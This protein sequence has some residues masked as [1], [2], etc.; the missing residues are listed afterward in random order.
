MK[1]IGFIRIFTLW[2]LLVGL[3]VSCG[4]D[5]RPS[6]VLPQD[7]MVPILK[8]LEIAYAGVGQVV[9][10]PKEQQIKYEEM[11]SMV[12]KKYKMDK[13]TFFSSFQWYEQHP[14]LLDTI[15]KQILLELNAELNL[16][17]G[18]RPQPRGKVP[19]VK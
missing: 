9:K 8:D 2:L 13:A 19:E 14:V 10:D 3:V 7:E 6:S 12:L 16:Q 11:N 5:S 15:F 17:N 4:S 1:R 18:R